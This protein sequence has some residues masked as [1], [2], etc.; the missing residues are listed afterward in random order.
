MGY[1]RHLRQRGG[2]AHFRRVVPGDLKA[3]FGRREIVRSVGALPLFERNSQCRRFGLACDEVFRIVRSQPSLTREDIGRLVA[4]YLD[5]LAK[6]DLEFSSRLPRRPPGE[7]EFRRGAQIS[8][9]SDL[10]RAVADARRTKTQVISE[11]ALAEVAKTAGVRFD[12]EGLDAFRVEDAL[13]DALARFYDQR[14]DELRSEGRI[15]RSGGVSQFIRDLLG[16]PGPHLSSQPAPAPASIAPEA[17]DTVSRAIQKDSQTPERRFE[18]VAHAPT[19]AE[20]RSGASQNAGEGLAR[21]QDQNSFSALWRSFIHTKV[22]VRR[23]WRPSRRPELLGT[24]RLWVWIVGDLPIAD[25]TSNH[26]TTFHDAYLMLPADYMRLRDAR[27]GML[28][29]EEVVAKATSIAEKAANG[30]GNGSAEYQR[31]NPKTFNKHL[32]NLKAFFA[33]RPIAEARAKDAPDPTRGF[34]IRIDKST[35]TVRAERNMAPVKAIA[36]LFESPFWT[37]RASEYFLT[38]PGNIIVRDSLYWIPLIVALHGLR[39]E[40]AAQLR[41]RHIKSIAATMDGVATTI[42]YFDLTAEDLVLKKPTEGSPRRVPFH[43]KFEQLGFLEDKVF[44]R[45]PSEHLFPELSNENAHAAFGVSVGKRFG[46][47]VSNLQFSEASFRDDLTHQAMRHTVRTLLDNTAAKEAFVDELLGHE[48]ENR[49]SEAKR[50]RK[51]VYLQNLKATIDLLDLPIDTER[52]R[53][54]ASTMA[55]RRGSSI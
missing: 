22:V 31:V 21:D 5:D 37:G 40:E 15:G 26:V 30:A 53:A 3:R 36:E 14:A 44:G 11:E 6:R 12:V 49:R 13:A 45:S 48:S 41:V 55:P 18:G 38:R 24:G 46:N 7:A 39:R 10:A 54:L 2:A 43:R 8:I 23:D 47:Y 17:V 27:K 29:P 52:L 33:W 50:Y 35:A 34:H 16:L 32:T 20:S 9:Y 25:L 19:K 1:G 51:E 4:V 42:W 28:S